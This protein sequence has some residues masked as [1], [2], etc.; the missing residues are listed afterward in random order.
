VC[1]LF[2]F[3]FLFLYFFS[4]LLSLVPAGARY[5]LRC[6]ALLLD[7]VVS[8]CRESSQG[9]AENHHHNNKPALGFLFL[10]FWSR[11]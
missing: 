6:G 7:V 8:G 2:S 10:G 4:G 5:L 3:L 1:A 9:I 11:A